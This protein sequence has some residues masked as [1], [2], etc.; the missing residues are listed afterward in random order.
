MYLKLVGLLSVLS[1]GIPSCFAV[2]AEQIKLLGECSSTDAIF[3]SFPKVKSYEKIKIN[4]PENI[5]L[6]YSLSGELRKSEVES[7]LQSINI[8]SEIKN[9]PQLWKM[10]IQGGAEYAMVSISTNCGSGNF[11]KVGHWCLAKNESNWV[12]YSKPVNLGSCVI[13]PDMP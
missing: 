9:I 4:T 11:F 13:S 7:I 8:K 1:F 12:V 5:T 6:Q 10:E 3:G 2:P